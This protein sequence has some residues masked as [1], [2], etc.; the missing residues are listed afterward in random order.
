MMTSHQ[1][2]WLSP[3]HGDYLFPSPSNKPQ[4]PGALRVCPGLYRDCFTFYL[5]IHSP[6]PGASTL[7]PSILNPCYSWAKCNFVF[8]IFVTIS[9]YLYVVQHVG[10]NV[11][12]SD[13]G[14]TE[15]DIV[16]SAKRDKQK[17]ET[18]MSHSSR[19]PGRGLKHG[20]WL[21]IRPTS[22]L[23][24]KGKMKVLHTTA[25]TPLCRTWVD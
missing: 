12:G 21:L 18:N 7:F 20:P 13:S 25:F 1:Q 19:S 6:H 3:Q 11:E 4:P 2:E 17:Q 10:N 15:G 22:Q 9:L 8:L 24:K 16:V 14:V 23:H 5:T